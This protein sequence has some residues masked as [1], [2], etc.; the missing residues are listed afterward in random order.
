MT[1]AC[2]HAIDTFLSRKLSRVPGNAVCWFILLYCSAVSGCVVDNSQTCWAKPEYIVIRLGN[3]SWRQERWP[4]AGIWEPECNAPPLSA[5]NKVARTTLYYCF[6]PFWGGSTM[7]PGYFSLCS[8]LPI[9]SPVHICSQVHNT[10]Y[11]E[12]V[13]Q[14]IR[15]RR[16]RISIENIIINNIIQIDLPD[17]STAALPLDDWMFIWAMF[18]VPVPIGWIVFNLIYKM[19]SKIAWFWNEFDHCRGNTWTMCEFHESTWNGFGD[20]WW[21]DNPIYFSSRYS[22]LTRRQNIINS[23]ASAPLNATKIVVKKVSDADVCMFGPE[24]IFDV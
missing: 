18:G 3:R 16:L 5:P 15:R 17:G 10:P 12:C 21:T 1:H 11:V 20:I 4:I 7:F 8:P 14:L 13:L 24:L 6:K 23:S 2:K 19:G 9:C 22:V